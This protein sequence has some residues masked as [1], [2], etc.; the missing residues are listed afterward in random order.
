MTIL[1]TLNEPIQ[2]V[3]RL[4]D[5]IATKTNYKE[6]QDTIDVFISLYIKLFKFSAQKQI[7][8]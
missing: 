6:K 5:V 7:W 2:S 3:K 4:H 1:K 8:L